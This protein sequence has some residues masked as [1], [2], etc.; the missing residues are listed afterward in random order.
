MRLH[1]RLL[2]M[3]TW[4]WGWEERG[5]IWMDPE[6][7]SARKLLLFNY[8]V[9]LGCWKVGKVTLVRIKYLGVNLP[10]ETKQQQQK[11]KKTKI[12]K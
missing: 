12:N 5:P 10:K 6:E 2:K 3:P 8:K 7:N 1:P 9:I 4:G 11:R